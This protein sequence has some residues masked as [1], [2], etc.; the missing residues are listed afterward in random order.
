MVEFAVRDPN[1]CTLAFTE[2]AWHADA[3]DV[4]AQ[5]SHPQERERAPVRRGIKRAWVPGVRA[6]CVTTLLLVIGVAV[7]FSR[8]DMPERIWIRGSGAGREIRIGTPS[9]PELAGIDVVSGWRS[10]DGSEE[11]IS[12]RRLPAP[13]E[14]WKLALV[15]VG[16][17]PRHRVYCPG[18]E[19]TG[20]TSEENGGAWREFV[21]FEPHFGRIQYG[22]WPW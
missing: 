9:G 19:A 16:V 20:Q 21:M 14:N 12:I 17:V 10:V 8:S 4:S 6:A 7:L 13:M 3:A 15:R 1:G 5:L 11:G 2:P 18:Y 22:W